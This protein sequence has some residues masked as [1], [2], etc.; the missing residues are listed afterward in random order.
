MTRRSWVALPPLLLLVACGATDSDAGAA[1]PAPVSAPAGAPELDVEV[2]LDGLDHPWDVAQAPDGTLLVD[3][4]AGGLTVVLPDGE[5]RPLDADLDD[6]FA[7][8]ETGLMGLALDPA[9]ADNRRF[10]TCQGVQTDAGAEV[11]VIAWT[12]DEAW[13]AAT[14]VADPLLGG[15]PVNSDSGRHGGC[16][17]EFGPDGA[18]FVGTGDNALGTNPQDLGSLAGKVLRIDPQTGEAL[19]G[20]PFT[21]DADAADRIWTYGHRNVQGLAVRPD[22]DQVYSV[23]HGPDRD[24]EVN[25]LQPGADFG[26]DPV[27]SGT[28]DESVP[29]TAPGDVPAVWSSGEPTIAPSGATFLDGAEWGDYDGLLLIGVQKDTGV[30]ALRLTEDGEL[31][32]SFRLPEL[33][34]TYGR[35][36]TPE[37]GQDGALY[38]TTDNGDGEDQ[39]LRVTPAS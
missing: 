11:Q 23:E 18:L 31:V 5:A 29:M 9:F 26:W 2:V 3:E 34:D 19:P 4:R 15:I 27:G 17:V 35:I 10:Y 25:L 8:G 33:E 7:E 38:V 14:R 12:V 30:L 28:Y 21:D 39:V 13:T 1:G 6:L 32:E 16:R 37:Q 22:S 36:R 24:D 20:N